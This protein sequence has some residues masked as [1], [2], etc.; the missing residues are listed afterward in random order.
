MEISEVE[1]SSQIYMWPDKKV[2]LFLIAFIC[3]LFILLARFTCLLCG[4]A[5]M[6]EKFYR[7]IRE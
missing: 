6:T 4:L 7:N 3:I 5:S 2:E 1:N